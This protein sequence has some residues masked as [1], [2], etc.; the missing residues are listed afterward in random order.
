MVCLIP[1]VLWSDT[2]VG[3]LYTSYANG[4]KSVP[5]NELVFELCTM[6][7]IIFSFHNHFY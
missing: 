4:P 6:L 5:L 1:F 2:L 3:L 7:P